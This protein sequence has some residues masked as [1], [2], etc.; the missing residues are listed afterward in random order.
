VDPPFRDAVPVLVA[1]IGVGLALELHEIRVLEGHLLPVA[2]LVAKPSYHVV[3][4]IAFC[5]ADAGLHGVPLRRADA[6]LVVT[7]SGVPDLPTVRQI[8]TV[9][10][11]VG[12]IGGQTGWRRQELGMAIQGGVDFPA[13]E[14]AH[15]GYRSR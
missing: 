5:I 6:P 13:V 9:G 7:H 14:Q 3:V 4:Q 1:R 8:V 12:G 15:W 10:V 2:T 11:E